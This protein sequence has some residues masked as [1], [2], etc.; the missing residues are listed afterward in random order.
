MKRNVGSVDRWLRAFAGVALAA[1]VLVVPMP[2]ALQVLGVAQGGYLVLTALAGYC[3][4]YRLLGRS[5]CALPAR[6]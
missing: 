1:L 5:T 4:G 2:L 3:V 6:R